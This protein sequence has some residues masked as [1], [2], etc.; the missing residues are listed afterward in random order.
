[1]TELRVEACVCQGSWASATTE[2]G[3]QAQRHR[4]DPAIPAHFPPVWVA[5]GV[6]GTH[7]SVRALEDLSGFL[8]GA[9][10]LEAFSLQG[11][12][13]QLL[14]ECIG[15]PL[16]VEDTVCFLLGYKN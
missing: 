12:R 14:Q 10:L 1:M 6:R 5:P 9:L 7:C 11:T 8:K 16:P 15:A 13:P 2:M 3:R 4:C